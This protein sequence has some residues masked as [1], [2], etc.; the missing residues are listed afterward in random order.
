[1]LDTTDEGKYEKT[2]GRAGLHSS[3]ADPS[4]LPGGSEREQPEGRHS[5]ALSPRLLGGVGAPSAQTAQG[6]LGPVVLG[7]AVGLHIPAAPAPT[8]LPL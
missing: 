5:P 8:L 4:Q 3:T 6:P 2:K 7:V 1:M